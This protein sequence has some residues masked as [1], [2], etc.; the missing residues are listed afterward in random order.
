VIR[1]LCVGYIELIR[2]VPLISVLFMASVMLPLFPSVRRDDGQAAARADRAH[3]FAAAYFAEVV[4][5][6]LQA[7]PKAQYE[8]AD[9]LG[10]TYLAKN[11]LLSSCRKRCAS[12]CRR[13]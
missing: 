2:G 6:G 7:I 13:S 5:G 4:R 9:A 1:A 12:R 11:D 8:M 3:L 10:L